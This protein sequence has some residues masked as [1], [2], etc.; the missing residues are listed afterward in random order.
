MQFRTSKRIQFIFFLFFF[1]KKGRSERACS[2][3][4]APA[5][6]KQLLQPIHQPA[7]GAP[8][9]PVAQQKKRKSRAESYCCSPGLAR[10]CKPSPGTRV[11]PP[12]A[13]FWQNRGSCAALECRRRRRRQTRGQTRLSQSYGLSLSHDLPSSEPTTTRRQTLCGYTSS[14]A[15][16]A[17]GDAPASVAV[18]SSV[19]RFCGS[20]AKRVSPRRRCRSE[21]RPVFPV[22]NWIPRLKRTRLTGGNCQRGQRRLL[23]LA[24]SSPGFC[25]AARGLRFLPLGWNENTVRTSAAAAGAVTNNISHGTEARQ[26]G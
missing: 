20:P 1:L 10:H 7:T 18:A 8:P 5:L 6:P 21:E 22:S 19:A 4:S 14:S 11:M 3:S 23:H 12:R 9:T 24:D 25:S 17:F 26:L 15:S 16:P 13:R 2:S